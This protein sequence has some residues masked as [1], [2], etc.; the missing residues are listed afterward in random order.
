MWRP[1]FVAPYPALPMKSQYQQ[2][3]DYLFAQLP[4]FHRIGAPAFKKDLTNTLLLC[5]HLGHPE[6]RFRSVH[7][8]GTN[9]K[10]SVAHM[11]AAVCTAAGLKTGL[12]TS[13]HYRDF[14]ERIKIDGMPIPRRTVVR[15]VQE[16]RVAFEQIK[17]SFFEWTVALAFHH[18]A[19]EK[20]DVAII[21]TGLGGRL[22]STNVITPLL[23]IITNIGF[24]HQQF[25]GDT[26]PAIAAEKAGII[27]PAV[28]VVI[29][30]TH[31][32]TKSV[33][34]Q[35]AELKNSP[36]TFADE[37]YQAE[38]LGHDERH[39]IYR[40]IHEGHTWP[41]PIALQHLADY[42]RF[43]LPTVLQA[44]DLLKSMLPLEEPHLRTG[45]EHLKDLTGFI[46]RWEFIDERP[47]VLVDS[48]H[49]EDGI[50]LL[51]E[52]LRRIPHRRL[53]FV[54]G[55]VQDKSL[56]R[57]LPLLPKEARYCFAKA[58]IPRGLDATTLQRA[59]RGPWPA[60]Q[61]VHLCA[62]GIGSCPAH[63]SPRRRPRRGRWEHFHCG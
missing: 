41:E 50:R 36:I 53:F 2:T 26:L 10:G 24:D 59:A 18:F 61:G 33:F 23:S 13:P 58:D 57:I 49:N 6:Q 55:V 12:Y 35:T 56:D 25:L 28:P 17:P 52:G 62:Q 21:E 20:V 47:R 7:I 43:N 44:F 22:D 40:I 46:G 42:Q 34:L 9:G 15:F 60:G 14:R 31:P 11:L 19:K 30:Q 8:A 37:H 38:P 32:A 51:V 39:T 27:K 5:E 3:L 4:M 45:L 1:L 29:G 48:A 63:G 54:L 16:H